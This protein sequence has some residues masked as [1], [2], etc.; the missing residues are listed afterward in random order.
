[1]K[2]SQHSADHHTTGV[3]HLITNFLPPTAYIVAPSVDIV[4]AFLHRAYD[5]PRFVMAVAGVILGSLSWGLFAE[6][7][8]A[9]CPLNVEFPANGTGPFGSYSHDGTTLRAK[10]L[11]AKSRW[12]S[13]EIIVLAA[14]A[15]ADVFSPDDRDRVD[16]WWLFQVGHGRYTAAQF[17]ATKRCLLLDLDHNLLPCTKEVLVRKVVRE[18]AKWQYTVTNRQVEEVFRRLSL[19]EP[20]PSARQSWY[21][22]PP[23]RPTNG[24]QLT[25]A[26]LQAQ[27]VVLREERARDLRRRGLPV[28]AATIDVHSSTALFRP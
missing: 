11:P 3:A 13:P 14:L 25:V 26:N 1:M 18:M 2:T 17:N 7:W 16:K 20:L 5:M 28:A 15:L 10:D 24:G 21:E 27:Q 23:G 9:Q 22:P 12:V 19:W 4:H 6:Q 8:R